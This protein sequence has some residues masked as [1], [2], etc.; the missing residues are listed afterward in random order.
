MQGVGF[1]PFIY[2]LAIEMGL[3]GWVSNASQGVFIEA[4]GSP[5]LLRALLRRIP[6]EKPPHSFI[7]SLE[8]SWLDPIGYDAFEVR[9]SDAGGEKTALVLPDIA[10][11]PDCLRE[12]FDPS[13]RR[14]RYPFTNCTHCGPRFSII[15]ALPYDRRNTTMKRFAL[16]EE[17]RAEYENP[18]NRRFHAQPNACPVCGPHL[19]LWDNRGETI[20]TH[21]DALL[22]AIEAIRNG[23]IVALKGLGGF[24]FI[25]GAKDNTG[26]EKLR[27]RKGREEKPFAVM[28][29]DLKMAHR[30]CEISEAEERLLLSPESPIVLLK[31]NGGSNDSIGS[32]VAPS[33]PTLGV[34]LPYTPLH[35]LLMRE[36][37]DFPIVA[38]SGNRSDE[39]ICIDEHEALE[40]L[41]A[42][43]DIFLVHDRPIARHVDDSIVRVILGRE[44][45]L[46]RARGYAPLPIPI[47]QTLPPI[48]AVGGHLKNTV[49]IGVGRNVFVSQHIGDLETEAAFDAFH[50][51]IESFERLYDFNPQ[52]VACDEHPDYVS[53]QFAAKTGL[54]VIPAQHQYTHV[55]SC[56]AENDLQ[57][58]ALGVS[59][60]GTGHGLDG[61]VWGGEF[62]RISS[63]SF[64]RAAHLRTFRLPGGE[65]AVKEPRRVALGLLYEY[66][67]EDL[68]EMKNLPPL[69]AFSQSELP[70]L[71]TMLTKG[72]NSPITS[73]AGRLFDAV[74][75]LLGIRQITRFEGQAAMEL[76]FSLDGVMTD[77]SYPFEI[78]PSLSGDIVDWSAMIRDI[79]EERERE[80]I[81]TI[82][83]RFHNTLIE[84]IVQVAQR[85]GEEKVVLTGGCFQNKYLTERAV[86]RLREAGFRPYWHQRIPPNDG[87]IALGQII[88]A[89]KADS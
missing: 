30:L 50:R 51:V 60:D 85:I 23:A 4:E 64:E 5:P 59:W 21:D 28:L 65:I 78:L 41:G 33:N 81:G 75:S 36:L 82:A 22:A 29:P 66:L 27:R 8:S 17:C 71:R 25:V 55:L 35:H 84:M 69:S 32:L 7:Q 58:P 12:I 19:E 72:L 63:I 44:M 24:Q 47:P 52:A 74:S 34:M 88:A 61:T 54:R 10:T 43:A 68:F 57:S 16:C 11:C 49:A 46:R 79:L 6:L 87:G 1:R 62:L 26:V 31:K 40:R 56:M 42:I 38:T 86:R 73:S 18:A 39:P 15:E 45:V 3:K 9:A 76:E 13:N 20:A 14:Y 2:H 67:G 80:K 89:G 70:V 83:A 77:K 53:T 48:L 37:G